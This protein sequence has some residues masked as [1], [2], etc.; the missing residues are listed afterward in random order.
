MN[1]T[2]YYV[3]KQSDTSADTLLAVGLAVLL[4]EVLQQV[5]KNSKGILIQNT[6]SHYQI[7]IPVPILESDL[8][9]IEHAPSLIR[10]LISEKQMAKQTKL[11]WDIQSFGFSYDEQM[12]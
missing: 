5:G 11:G 1:T 7:H 10:P 12:A 3:D 9:K 2:L 6:H 4:R 8:Q